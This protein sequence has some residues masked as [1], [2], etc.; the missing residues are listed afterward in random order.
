MYLSFK[1]MQQFICIIT[2]LNLA[3]S[4]PFEYCASWWRVSDTCQSSA[5]RAASDWPSSARLLIPLLSGAAADAFRL[6]SAVAWQWHSSLHAGLMYTRAPGILPVCWAAFPLFGRWVHKSE[7]HHSRCAPFAGWLPPRSWGDARKGHA[8]DYLRCCIS[9]AYSAMRH[10]CGRTVMAGVF[11]A[12][13]AGCQRCE[14]DDGSFGEH[15]A[16]IDGF[17]V[18]RWEG[19]GFGEADA[20]GW[21]D[22]RLSQLASKQVTD[23]HVVERQASRQAGRQFRVII[24]AVGHADCLVWACVYI[25]IHVNWFVSGCRC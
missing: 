18:S 1:G 12:W 24:W 21:P 3:R 19:W 10:R 25:I 6:A 9:L 7:S 15:C 22:R 16:D 23:S 4:I 2:L 17:P 11:C 5:L 13:A 8:S 20:V 14:F